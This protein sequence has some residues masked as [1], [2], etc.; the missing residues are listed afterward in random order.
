MM[1]YT[2]Y[3]LALLMLIL[4]F[5]FVDRVALGIVMQDIKIDLNLTD[6]QLGFLSGIAFAAFYAIMGIPIARWADRG[7]RIRIIGITTA[8]WSLA[9]ALCGFA[10]TF[11]QLV[12]F[13]IGVAIGEAGCIPPAHSLIADNFSREERPRAM[14]RYMLGLP[15]GFVIGYLAAGWLSEIYGWRATF[16]II[17]LPGLVL[18]AL[19]AFTL[20]EPRVKLHKW[21]AP[22]RTAWSTPG[23]AFPEICITLWRIRAFRHLLTCFSV[24]YFFGY[25]LTQWLPAFFVRSHGLSTGE[26][27][28]WFAIIA[29][30]CGGLGVFAGGELASRCAGSNERIQLYGCAVAFAFFALL[31]ALALFVPNPYLALVALAIGS[32]GGNMAQG[33]I[34]A[35]I[36][37]LVPARMRA[38]SIAL[39]YLFANLVG[40]GLGP[41]A[42]GALSDALAPHFGVDSLRYALLIL[43]PGYFWASWHL[44]RAGRT[45]VQDLEAAQ[46]PT[47]SNDARLAV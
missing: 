9:A 20:K 11:F 5:N 38:T 6:T 1:T 33:P 39:V 19:A 32:F 30:V 37:T 45:V 22:P 3:L 18:A 17:G 15:L 44:M 41:L 12:A 46:Q 7:N 21:T 2:N 10:L 24:W 43:C 31:N 8:L 35:S 14:A 4:G 25:G 26:L 40:M 27:G 47:Q 29:G 28:T 34:L 23:P 16:V 36:Q 42:A 13:R